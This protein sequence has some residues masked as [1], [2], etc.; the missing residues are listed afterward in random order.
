MHIRHSS[1]N[2]TQRDFNSLAKANVWS[3]LVYIDGPHLIQQLNSIDRI[4]VTSQ[5]A[6]EDKSLRPLAQYRASKITLNVA[7]TQ[8][9][10]ATI[11]CRTTLPILGL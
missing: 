10:L 1:S 3:I 9:S 6:G 8:Y 7:S 5:K 11:D 2:A 4:E